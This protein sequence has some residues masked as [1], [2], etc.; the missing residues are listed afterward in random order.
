MN[1]ARKLSWL[2]PTLGIGSAAAL[3]CV[4]TGC[5]KTPAPQPG[6]P[7]STSKAT[8]PATKS[9][10]GKEAA[11]VRPLL[12]DWAKPAVALMLSGELHGYLEPCGC[13]LTQSGGL[14]RRGDLQRQLQE[15]GWSVAAFDVGDVLKRTRRQDQIKF[16][17]ILNGLKQLGYSAV[18]AGDSELRLPPDYLIGQFSEGDGIPLGGLLVACNVVLFD[19]PDLGVPK[20]YTITTV[21]DTKIA[22]TSVVCPSVAA[23]VA[24]EGVQ[25]QVKIRP[26]SEVLRE[27]LPKIEAEQPALKILMTNGTTAEAE[28]LAKEFP[29]FPVIVAAGGPEDPAD[30][31][32]AVGK[33]LIVQTGHKGKYVGILGYYPGETPALRWELVNLDN[34]RFHSDERMHRVME[35]YQQ[36][37][38]DLDLAR[39][40]ELTVPQPRG[41]KYVG[42]AVCG[43][44]HKQA[45]KKWQVSKHAHAFES[46]ERGRKGQEANWV[47]RVYDPEC[48]ACHVTGWD[49]QNVLR[50]DSGYL[51]MASTAHL[52]GQQCE[53]CHGAGDKHTQLE[54]SFR[55]DLKS[56]DRNDLFA[57][58]AALKLNYKTA[59]IEVCSKCHDHENS[60]GFKFEKYWDE[61]KHPW[62]D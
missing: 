48:L 17:A 16:E 5:P 22:V 58:R 53:N 29:E 55:K 8:S 59:E 26:A 43:E 60:P 6:T 42:A 4:L 12:K 1:T 33:T 30:Q 62:K 35:N 23:D 20:P 47:S 34:V 21:G 44:C 49:P 14:E 27:I 13:S 31:P 9:A 2:R 46:L 15:K 41:D 54:R 24:P 38:K 51:D 50:Y 40:P 61:V 39:S 18:G 36:Q 10:Q 52:A 45:Y 37:L 7:P 25:S 3:L 11:Y 28:A 57:A 32:R 56:V 19:A